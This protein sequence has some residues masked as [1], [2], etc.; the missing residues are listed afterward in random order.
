MFHI[1]KTL[2]L[3]RHI[4]KKV[5]HVGSVPSGCRAPGLVHQKGLG[6]VNQ[7]EPNGQPHLGGTVNHLHEL[8]TASQESPSGNWLIWLGHENII[9]N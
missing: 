6:L 4:T 5:R 8:I 9:G 2:R 7:V 1:L 3:L